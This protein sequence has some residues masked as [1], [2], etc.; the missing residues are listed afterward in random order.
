MKTSYG[1]SFVHGESAEDY[2]GHGTHVAG[3]I[4]AKDNGYG[5]K[6]IAAGAWVVP[7]KVFRRTGGAYHSTIVAALNWVYKYG[8]PGDIVNIS[9]GSKI[10]PSAPQTI[11][12]TA[13]KK[14]AVKGIRVVISAGN[15]KI[16]ARGYHPARVNGSRIYTIASTYKGPFP[17]AIGN[18]FAAWYSNYGKNPVDYAAPGTTIYSTYKYGK[19]AYMSGTSMAA[20]NFAGVILCGLKRKKGY[21]Y[22]KVY[23]ANHQFY[24]VRPK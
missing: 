20:P 4:A 22:V 16:H 24:V 11:V 6:G 21:S 13:I 23:P 10:S 19:Y 1:K 2:R 17:W 5:A 8:I 14:L 15:S 7:L 3:I 18:Y 12:E 9:L